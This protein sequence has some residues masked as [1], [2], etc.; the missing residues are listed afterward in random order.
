MATNSPNYNFNDHSDIH[1]TILRGKA[2]PATRKQFVDLQAAVLAG[3]RKRDGATVLGQG[4]PTRWKL[5]EAADL[6]LE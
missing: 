3:R 5:K 6:M 4:V 1:T 2:V